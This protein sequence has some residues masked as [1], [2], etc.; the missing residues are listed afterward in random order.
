MLPTAD[1]D[2]REGYWT[3]TRIKLAGEY[4]PLDQRQMTMVSENA[5][6]LSYQAGIKF[7]NIWDSGHRK[8]GYSFIDKGISL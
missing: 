5:P 8:R 3:Q 7:A 1:C 4:L 2:Q 6:K